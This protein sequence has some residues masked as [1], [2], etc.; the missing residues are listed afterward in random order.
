MTKDEISS[1]YGALSG[2][3]PILKPWLQERKDEL[4]A[5]LVSVNDEQTRGRIKELDDILKLPE[6]LQNESI[7][8]QNVQEEEGLS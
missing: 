5:L 8:F 7:G 1:L 3:W 4:T 2:A 6:R